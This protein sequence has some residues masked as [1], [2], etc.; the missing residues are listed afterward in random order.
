MSVKRRGQLELCYLRKLHDNQLLIT[1][2]IVERFGVVV[3]RDRAAVV[4][5]R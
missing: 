2:V 5:R 1:E 4:F 3:K